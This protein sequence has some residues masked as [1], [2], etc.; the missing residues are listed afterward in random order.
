MVMLSNW[1]EQSKNIADKS[2]AGQADCDMLL[3]PD[4]PRVFLYASPIC[5]SASS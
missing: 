2:L 1:P 3:G 4:Q 5:S